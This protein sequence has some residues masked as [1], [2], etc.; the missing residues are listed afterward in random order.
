V[1]PAS[2]QKMTKQ[3]VYWYFQEFTD[4]SHL[5]IFCRRITRVLCESAVIWK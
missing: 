2:K 1:N 3:G 5:L 4:M